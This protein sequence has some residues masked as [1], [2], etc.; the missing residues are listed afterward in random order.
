MEQNKC[1]LGKHVAFIVCLFIFISFICM[2]C[3]MDYVS[4]TNGEN[5]CNLKKDT[6]IILIDTTAYASRSVGTDSIMQNIKDYSSEIAIYKYKIDSLSTVVDKVNGQYA[7]TIDMLIDK[8]NTWVGFWLAVLSLVLLLVS[9]WQYL[10]IDKHENEIKDKMDKT[11]STHKFSTLENRMTSLLLCMSSVPDPQ[12]FS[13][14]NERKEQISY[15]LGLVSN[16]L[17]KYFELINKESKNNCISRETVE[18]VPMVLL[19]LRLAMIRLQGAF[20]DPSLYIDFIRLMKQIEKNESAIRRTKLLDCEKVQE[21]AALINQFNNFKAQ[22]D[23]CKE[24]V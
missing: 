6:I 13:D 20:R 8:F 2:I 21:L 19:N 11:M 15:Y 10:K 5:I 12:V 14:S 4:C 3:R 7:S 18:C 16:L 1:N 24:V 17:I 23:N 22:I 9:A